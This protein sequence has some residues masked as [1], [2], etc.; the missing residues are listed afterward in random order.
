MAKANAMNPGVAALTTAGGEHNSAWLFVLP[1]LLLSLS[2]VAFPVAATVMFSF[3]EWNGLGTPRFIGLDNFEAMVGEARFWTAIANNFIYTAVFVTVPMIIALVAAALLML[4]KAGRTFFQ[5]V[6]F[7]PVTIATIILAQT[8]RGM[9]YSPV[10]GMVGWLQSFGLNVA[11]PLADPSTALY[12]ILLVDIWHWWGYLCVI[13]FAALRQV[14]VSLIEAAFVDGASY[15]ATFRYILLPMILPT[16]LF[17]LLMTVIWS[18]RV[19]DWVFVLTEGGPGFS[20]EVL[21]TL[22]YK[23]AFQQMSIGRASAYSLVM[24]LLGMLAISIYLR[25]QYKSEKQS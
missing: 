16:I 8:W 13:Y 7:L 6:F 3:T 23:T 2:V 19:F 1:A 21:G 17:M 25:V 22:A 14:D 15:V 18:F 10:T 5:V 24:S 11:N 9:I 4:I 20:S 12:G